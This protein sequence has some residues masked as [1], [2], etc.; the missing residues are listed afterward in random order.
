MFSGNLLIARID[1]ML[2]NKADRILTGPR[3]RSTRRI[4]FHGVWSAMPPLQWKTR[5][6]LRRTS[7]AFKTST[8][9]AIFPGRFT[10]P[11]ADGLCDRMATCWAARSSCCG[12]TNGRD[13]SHRRSRPVALDWLQSIAESGVRNVGR[14]DSSHF[15]RFATCESAYRRRDLPCLR[16]SNHYPGR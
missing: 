4:R 5:V 9:R 14:A 11:R 1:R 3:F 8:S 12:I 16:L 6:A 15:R 7:R 2:L 10:L 13:P